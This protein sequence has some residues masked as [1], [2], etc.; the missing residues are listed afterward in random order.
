MAE[1]QTVLATM[2][3]KAQAWERGVHIT[4]GALNLI[5]IFFFAISWNFHKNG[6]PVMKT[7][8]EDPDISI[9]MTQG[10]NRT[11]TMP[12][13]RVEVTKGKHTLGV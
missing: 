7:I 11:H 10:N 3:A 2:Q 1:I 4:G 8:N 5:K 12:I 9:D 6:Q 13:T